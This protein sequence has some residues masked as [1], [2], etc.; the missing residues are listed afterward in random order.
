MHKANA[1][2][3]DVPLITPY[4]PSVSANALSNSFHNYAIEW[5][6][7]QI[8]YFFDAI[9]YAK[10]SQDMMTPDEWEQFKKPHY[11]ILNLAMGG[12]SGG[13]IDTSKFPFT[14]EI[15]YVRYYTQK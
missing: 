3:K 2:G 4:A 6:S 1:E 5:D 13:T 8:A 7:T 11:I 14:Y 15:D 12:T 10:F 9:E